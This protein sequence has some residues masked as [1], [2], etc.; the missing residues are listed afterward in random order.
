MK[1][2]EALENPNVRAFLRAIRLGE[3]TADD[4]GYRRIVGG[5]L[6]SDFRDHPRKAVWLPRYRL[7]STAAGAYQFLA[8]TWDE[9]RRAYLLPDFSPRSQDLAAVG[10]LIRRGA[11]A[12]VIAGRIDDAIMRCRLEWAS[13]PGSPYGQ[14]TEPLA[15]VIAEYQAHGGRLLGS[16]PVLAGAPMPTDG[17]NALLGDPGK[18]G[19]PAA[20]PA[21]PLDVTRADAR[22]LTKPEN[23]DGNNAETQEPAP[24]DESRPVWIRGSGWVRRG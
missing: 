20:A 11:L 17:Q 10:L 5:G 8:G 2:H 3:G 19:G 18:P 21:D 15:R 4:D 12:D 24:I 22:E 6:C 9:M 7:A 14:R 16:P 23:D 13:L 1:P